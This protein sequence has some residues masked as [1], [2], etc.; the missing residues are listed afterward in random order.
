[1]RLL[2]NGKLLVVRQV[3]RVP[4]LALAAGPRPRAR[5]AAAVAA[6]VG[7]RHVQRRDRA[8]VR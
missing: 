4:L 3:V 2:L 6:V 7:R 5:V 8:V 1:V